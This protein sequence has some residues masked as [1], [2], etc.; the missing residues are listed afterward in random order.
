MN[1]EERVIRR[2][3]TA[4]QR[5]LVPAFVSGVIKKFGDDNGGAPVA[6]LAYAAEVNV[7]LARRLWP[8]AFVQPPLTEA[9]RASLALQACRI[10]GGRNSRWR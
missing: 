1:P 10:S 4:Q 8:R 3:D 6:N 9:D 5:H 7:V 2:I